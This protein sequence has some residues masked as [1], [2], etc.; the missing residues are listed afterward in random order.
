MTMVE[1]SPA[2]PGF[3]W[4]LG[5]TTSAVTAQGTLAVAA[6]LL[7]ASLTRSPIAVATVAACAWL[8]WLLVGL[9]A[10]ALTERWP[11]RAVMVTTD[12]VR[13]LLLLALGAAVLAGW[14][15]IPLLAVI[16]FSVGVGGCFFDP[17]AQSELPELV[18]RDPERLGKANATYWSVDTMARTLVGA[19]IGGVAFA[20]HPVA[21]FI[22]SGALLASSAAM[23]TRLP[24]RPAGEVSKESLRSTVA[25]GLRTVWRI[26]P[27]RHNAILTAQYNLAW[28]LVF[29]TAILLLQDHMQISD[30]AWGLLVASTA[31]GGVAGGAWARRSTRG[32]QRTYGGAMLV[33]A[34]GWM[35]VAFATSPWT[36]LP[37]FVVI[38]AASTAVSAV[39]GASMQLASPADHLARVTSAIRMAGTGAAAIGA[40]LSGLVARVGGLSAPTVAAVAVLAVSTCYAWSV[41]R[42]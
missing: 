17:A 29:A 23:L 26:T 7:A 27:L 37:G 38:G 2:A 8:P 33:Q 25:A 36:A 15:S 16:V 1:S 4:L 32:L 6:P 19:S 42:P 22:C 10:G 31:L 9:A 21:P 35:V 24:N 3:A 11:N 5:S 34:I 40:A 14:A 12:V 41:R 39:A 13:A 20:I 28:N 18:G 30:S